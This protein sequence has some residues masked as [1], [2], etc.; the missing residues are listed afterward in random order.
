MTF[1]CCGSKDFLSALERYTILL[2]GVETHICVNQT[3]L[4]LLRLG[5]QVH[6]AADAVSSRKES[7]YRIGLD[8]MRQAGAVITSTEMAVFEM[9]R[10]AAAPEFK[11][12][13]E[14]VK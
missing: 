2:C 3:A 1:S 5:Y 4:D 6:V 10:D 14:L 7:N 9:L 12:I 13:L 8:R 11:R